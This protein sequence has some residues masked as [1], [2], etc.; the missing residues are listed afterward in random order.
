MIDQTY[1]T[2]Y[3]LINQLKSMTQLMLCTIWP[4]MLTIQIFGDF[5]ANRKDKY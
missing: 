3:L 2:N 5:P 4:E 1:C